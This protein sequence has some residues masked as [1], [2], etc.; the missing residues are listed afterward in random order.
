M[1]EVR[2]Y[3]EEMSLKGLGVVHG[4]GAWKNGFR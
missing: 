4:N 1:T 3:E 2:T